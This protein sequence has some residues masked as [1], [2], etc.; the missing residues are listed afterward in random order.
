MIIE[1]ELKTGAVLYL[2]N[3][4]VLF[5]TWRLLFDSGSEL[6]EAVKYYFKPDLIS[7]ISGDGMEDFIAEFKLSLLFLFPALPAFLE[8]YFL[9]N[10]F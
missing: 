9:G 10:Y 4:P 6:W 5:F 8:Y 2:L 1:P 3:T 7:W